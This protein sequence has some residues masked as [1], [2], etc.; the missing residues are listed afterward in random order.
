[1]S[2]DIQTF[3]IFIKAE[4]YMPSPSDQTS[5]K[6][7]LYKSDL[8]NI[9]EMIYYVVDVSMKEQAHYDYSALSDNY[10]TIHIT[11][12]LPTLYPEFVFPFIF[13]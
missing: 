9:M 2:P 13:D 11:C 10:D 7:H 8:Y 1:M 6:T 5:V 12:S 3:N 4:V